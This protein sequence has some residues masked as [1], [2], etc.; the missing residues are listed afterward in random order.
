MSILNRI[1][2]LVIFPALAFFLGFNKNE[3]R[4]GEPFN[5]NA[6]KRALSVKPMGAAPQKVFTDAYANIID[7]Y[8]KPLDSTE[9]KYSA[10]AGAVNALGDPHTIF[11]DPDFATAF[12]KETTGNKD[13]VGVGARLLQHELGAKIG[14]IFDEGP[15]YKAGIRENDIIV[16]VDGQSTA[17]KSTTE[18]VKHIRGPE[19]STVKISV[20]QSGSKTPQEFTCTRRRVMQPTIDGKV[21][22]GTNIG[23]MAIYGFAQVTPTEFSRTLDRL[24]AESLRGLVID[25]R[26]NGGGLLE[27]AR[28]MLS[29]FFVD[30]LVVTMR[31]RDGTEE[32]TETRGDMKRDITCPIAILVDE[33]TASASEIFSGTM[34]QYK[35][36]IL[37]GTHTYGKASV[38]NL[39][40]V[41]K[42][43][44]TELKITIAKYF[45]PDGA[46]ISRKQDD[47]G[48][49]ISGGLKPD[50]DL[51]LS[52]DPRMSPGDPEL[53]N[54]LKKA[55]EY[56]KEKTP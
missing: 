28:D 2:L 12:T 33:N 34:R 47:D 56:I 15:A 44:G 7:A 24:N 13:F 3:L 36:A 41:S 31:R 49:Y 14:F 48:V 19:G 32:I 29:N 43:E 42:Q 27:S 21:L 40:P 22:E 52:L 53:D 6:F 10:M 5:K 4:N 26:G 18:I 51:P 23:Y 45:L 46:D 9:L 25:L 38:Q 17:G 37:V 8:S 30:K 16:A 20:L 55:I 39:Y 54:Q 35:R 50:F 11:L 1:A